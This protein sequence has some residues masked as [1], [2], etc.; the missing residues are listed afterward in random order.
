MEASAFH[1]VI[2]DSITGRYFNGS[3][4]TDVTYR[5]GGTFSISEVQQYTSSDVVAV[6]KIGIYYTASVSN[7]STNPDYITFDLYPEFTIQN[8][9]YIYSFIGHSMQTGISVS[10]YSPPRWE[11]FLN[12]ITTVFQDAN[13]VNPNQTE[14]AH[15]RAGISGFGGTWFTYAE[16]NY[17]SNVATSGYSLRASFFGTN[18]SRTAILAIGCPYISTG[19]FGQSGTL[20]VTTTSPVPSYTVVVDNAGVESR[21]DDVVSAVD[22]LG[23]IIQQTPDYD[24]GSEDDTIMDAPS[25]VDEEAI[26][27]AMSVADTI[28]DDIPSIVAT[29][30]F[31]MECA[32]ALVNDSAFIIIVP[33]CILLSF[34]VYL[35]WKK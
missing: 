3:N 19:G 28:L 10:A 17:V 26:E 2:G 23:D 35:W 29:G 4:Y 15:F 21:L 31:W 25:D 33:L 13:L 7:V 18:A 16:C 5:Y 27:N 14:Y 1:D 20:P 24:F 32:K 22:N 12:G 6:N 8:T 34:I 9:S 11:W 30:A